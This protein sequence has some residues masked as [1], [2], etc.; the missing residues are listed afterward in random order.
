MAMFFD[1]GTRFVAGLVATPLVQY[2]DATGDTAF[3]QTRLAPFLRQIASFYTSYAVTAHHGVN[4]SNSSSATVV[5]PYT[6]AQ[7]TCAGAARATQNAHQDL[8][9]ARMVYSKVRDRS[10]ELGT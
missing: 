8:S 10:I 2:Y 1:D 4:G 3:L 6:C 7:E 9:Y 5:L